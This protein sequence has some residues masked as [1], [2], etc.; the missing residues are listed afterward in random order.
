MNIELRRRPSSFA[1]TIGELSVDGIFTA[2]SL[3]DVVREIPGK[4]VSSWKIDDRTAIP[5]G[6]YRVII[7]FSARFQQDM[8]LLLDVPGFSGVRI[9]SGNTSDDTSGC[10]LVGLNVVDDTVTG[11]HIAF[12]RLFDQIEKALSQS[13]KV[14][15]TVSNAWNTAH[16]AV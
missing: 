2:F 4:P 12:H 13:D 10:I 3:E 14:W 5:V 8:P 9:H 1:S 16:A 15:I 6:R 7:T 11:S